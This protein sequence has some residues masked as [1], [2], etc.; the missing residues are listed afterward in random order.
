M[1][2]KLILAAVLAMAM[3]SSACGGIILDG[4]GNVTNWS[5]TPFALSNQ[6]NL[7]QG[8]TWSTIQ[9]NYA[10][11]SY[12]SIGRQPSPGNNSGGEVYDLEELHVRITGQQVQLLLVASTPWVSQW[13]G[14]NIYLGD[15]ML[16]IDGRRFG[17]VTQSATQGLEQGALYRL[18]NPGDTV[19]IQ[20]QAGSYGDWTALM[21]NDYGPNATVSNIIGPWAVSSSISTSEL[22]GTAQ[23]SSATFNYGGSENGTFLL[24][25]VFDIGLLGLSEPGD[26]TAQVAWGCGNDV[27]RTSG[28]T[29]PVVPEPGTVILLAAGSVFMFVSSRRQRRQRRAA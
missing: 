9:N 3:A 24:E 7:H 26:V 14:N 10:P 13:G 28:G 21:A 15:M 6:S 29:V 19:G 1:Y 25:Y 8:N 22:L 11:I 2:G 20:R 17:I 5:L 27:I 4:E 12:P 18:A 16:T 23:I